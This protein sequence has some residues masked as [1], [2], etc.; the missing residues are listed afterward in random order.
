M[1][2]AIID[3]VGNN[4]VLALPLG[5][6]KANHIA[7]AL[8]ER[9]LKDSSITLEIITAL[10]LE[11]PA[12]GDPFTRRLLEPALERLFG[13]SPPL[14][15]AQLLRDDALPDNIRISEFFLQAGQWLGVTTAQQN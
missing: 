15:Y 5:L 9:A 3:Q 11:T 6:G 2:D 14:R 12:L 4:V 13:N 10:T 1:A 7:N 8:T